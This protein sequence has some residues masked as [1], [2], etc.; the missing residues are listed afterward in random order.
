MTPD[1]H[2]YFGH[3]DRVRI[4]TTAF[5]QSLLD[6]A[7]HPV[8]LTPLTQKNVRGVKEGTNAFTFR[9]FLVPYLRQ[10]KSWALFVDGSDMLCRDDINNILQYADWYKAVSVV[11]HDYETKHP[12]KYVGSTMEADNTDYPRKQ[13]ASVMLM[14]CSHY[15]WR[16]VTPK[17]VESAD[18][19]HLLQLRFMSDELIGELPREW[20]WLVDEHGANQAANLI[21]FTA[22]VPA[23]PGHRDAPM[24]AEWHA[25]LAP[26]SAVE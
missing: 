17:F 14:N 18:P 2:V 25:A 24:A 8:G 9:R 5:V 19:L 10:W 23:I 6:H 12:R 3:D 21:H 13:W 4:G 1:L 7:R 16:R 26:G 15:A 22:G 20:N 11:K